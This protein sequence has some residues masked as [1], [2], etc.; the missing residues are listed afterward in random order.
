MPNQDR[1]ISSKSCE[2]EVVL[3]YPGKYREANPQIPLSLLHV[4]S[5]LQREDYH[6]R[7]FDMRVENYEDLEL[8]NPL[9]IGL[10]C[11]SGQQIRYGLKLARKV[12]E[13]NPLCPIVWGG[14]HP[15]L[16][17][18]QRAACDLVDVVVRGEAESV[19]VNLA[20]ELSAH[21]QLQLVKG[22]TYKAEGAIRS[23]P[24]S[25]LIDLNT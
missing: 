6:V 5:P 15:T 9:F 21:K 12:R 20:R 14:V 7:I 13:Q 11:M 18:E 1:S 16:L 17:P 8:G 22:I 25:D 2:K 4:A 10:S 19:I 24:D 23:N 3:V